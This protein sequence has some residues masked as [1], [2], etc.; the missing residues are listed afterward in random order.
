MVFY[1]EISG[2]PFSVNKYTNL[3]FFGSQLFTEKISLKEAQEQQTKILDIIKELEKKTNP[4]KM[5]RPLNK[6]TKKRQKN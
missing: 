6:T 5:G 2:K 1:V 3:T 4:D